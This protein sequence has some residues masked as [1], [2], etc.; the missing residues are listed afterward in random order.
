VVSLN[1]KF[2]V[3]GKEEKREKEGLRVSCDECLPTYTS[4]KTASLLLNSFLSR[5]LGV[6]SRARILQIRMSKIETTSSSS[7]SN[8]NQV[9]DIEAEAQDELVQQEVDQ[10][11]SSSHHQLANHPQSFLNSQLGWDDSDQEE[12]GEQE[13]EEEEEE[14]GSDSGSGS[15]DENDYDD[16]EEEQEENGLQQI[17]TRAW[18]SA[19]STFEDFNPYQ[20]D[21]EDAEA[22]QSAPLRLRSSKSRNS[23][24]PP[25][26][27][28]NTKTFKSRFSS[29]WTY[30]TKGSS[31]S[32]GKGS[33]GGLPASLS[34]PLVSA[35]LFAAS[36][37]P[38]VLLS[39]PY[40]F[41]LTGVAW[42]VVGLILIAGL[43]GVGG[44]LFVVLSRYVQGLTVEE[45]TG[46]SFGRHNRWKGNVGRCTSGLLLATY[47]MMAAWVAYGGEFSE[48]ARSCRG[49]NVEK[50]RTTA[51]RTE[52]SAS[53]K[54]K[55]E[56]MRRPK[57]I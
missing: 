34:L 30:L 5:P 19:D 23:N 20:D 49:W 42:G 2:K 25:P 18:A 36:L 4:V 29:V 44:G 48:A 26:S 24:H 9:Q 53:G 3:K 7:P 45:I 38:G 39:M 6:Q 41:G 55:G 31:H 11:A 12:E 51:L 37:H 54:I 22:F 50:A 16:Q 8:T 21:P 46:Q 32:R 33:G 17:P 14:D 52:G 28:Q 43:G 40:Y 13:N 10:I 47:A 35:N 1:I 56:I 27:P 57:I 15:N